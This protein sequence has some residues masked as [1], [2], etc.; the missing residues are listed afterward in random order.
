MGA[1]ICTDEKINISESEFKEGSRNL[2]YEDGDFS[3]NNTLGGF[4]SIDVKKI[5]F[6]TI[7]NEKDDFMKRNSLSKIL[8][9]Y[10]K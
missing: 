3:D 9:Y 7:I 5:R 10:N 2:S 8:Y 1:L 6:A 4:S